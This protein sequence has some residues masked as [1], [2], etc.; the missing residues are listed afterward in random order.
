[1]IE[2]GEASEEKMI[3][4]YLQAE[5][6]SPR[7]GKH[8]QDPIDLLNI[9][10]SA[11]VANPDRNSAADNAARRRLLGLVRG[12]GGDC[13]L[14]TGFPTNVRWRH[15]EL[16]P[17]EHGR[18]KYARDAGWDRHSDG[19]LSVM[20]CAEK[21]ERNEV[22]PDPADHIRMVQRL[23]TD[24]RTFP[25]II[26]V[27]GKGEDLVIVE[28]FVRATAYVASKISHGIKMFLGSSDEMQSW[29][30]C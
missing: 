18:L 3:L 7:H 4:A 23:L 10:C 22:P 13:A 27:E 8:Y 19:T 6:N 12:Y 9:D 28:G 11:L 29:R 21:M 26:A 1:M 24:G 14:F 15:V 16:E 2:L 25:E 30:R 20:R 5:I 17:T